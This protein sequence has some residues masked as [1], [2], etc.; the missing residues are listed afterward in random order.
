MAE[1]SF[2]E[3]VVSIQSNLKVPKNQ[4]NKFGNYSYRNAED[5]L[6]AVKPMLS[7]KGLMLTL[8]DEPVI[9]EDRF[10]I[11]A[12]A[13][14]TDGEHFVKVKGYAR[15]PATK[16]GMDESQITGTASSYAR[17]YAL[18]GLFLIDDTK[19][20]DTNENRQE[21]NERAKMQEKQSTKK[22]NE[23]QQSKQ[24]KHSTK[25]NAAQQGKSKNTQSRSPAGLSEAQQ[26]VAVEKFT[27]FAKAQGL[28]VK[29][30][31]DKL[32]PYL[33]IKSKLPQLTKDDYGTL[34]AYLNQH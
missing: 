33:K 11:K 7:E 15:E 9:L 12:V 2:I 16:K 19:D 17:K 27:A 24:E 34:M 28:A 32:F 22:G 26:K 1:Q 30:A 10:Y 31:E 4:W 21:R 29:D 23:A 13:T 8:T 3:K 18:N 25:E 6:E 20:A 5:I 14:L